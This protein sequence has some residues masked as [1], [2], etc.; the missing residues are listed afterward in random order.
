MNKK[1]KAVFQGLSLG[2]L[3]CFDFSGETAREVVNSY[4]P[5]NYMKHDAE[6]LLDNAQKAWVI[7]QK[8][9]NKNV[10]K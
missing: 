5:K 4:F 10:C 9:G 3:F 7:C 2:F 8:R 1:L 6:A